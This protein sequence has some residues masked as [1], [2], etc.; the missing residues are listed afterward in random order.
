MAKDCVNLEMTMKH[1]DEPI[2]INNSSS[3][4]Y[5]P[6]HP[7]SRLIIGG[8]RSGKA[9]VILNLINQQSYIEKSIYTSKMHSKESVNY[10]S[11]KEKNPS[12][13]INGDMIAD[14]E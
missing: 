5:I 10:S 3:W 9:N 7:N 13:N 12:L 8:L 11:T 14:M 6:D 1:F 2:I 4:P